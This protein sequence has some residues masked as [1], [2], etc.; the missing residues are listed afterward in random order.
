MRPHSRTRREARP[1][2]RD[3]GRAAR[4]R[5]RVQRRHRQH[6]RR[7]GRVPRA[8]ANAP[9]RSRPT[10]RACARP[11]STTRERLAALIGIRHVVVATEEFDNP[12]YLKNDGTRCYHCKTELYSTVEQLLP[13]LGVPVVVERGEPRRPAATTG[14]VWSRPPSTRCGIRCRRPGSRR[15]TCGRWRS[16]GACRRGTSRRRRACRAGS[17]RAWR[18]RRSA[19]RASRPRRRCFARWACASAACAITR[20]TWPASR[21]RVGEIAQLRGR[22]GADRTGPRVPPPRVQVR[23]AR[24]RRLPL[25]QPERTGPAGSP[26]RE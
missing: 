18:S 22:A 23:D 26:P 17:P 1:A 6:R 14:P 21:C 13:E 10:A 19:R 5:G 12:D 7:E 15:P 4:R 24:P 16:T 2:A 9:S 11:S 3:P 20:A 8:R 25:R